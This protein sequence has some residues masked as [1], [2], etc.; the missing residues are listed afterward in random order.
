[1]EEKQLLGSIRIV[2]QNF[3]KSFIRHRGGRTKYFKSYIQQRDHD[4]RNEE[5]DIGYLERPNEKNKE[6]KFRNTD[7]GALRNEWE[8]IKSDFKG[9]HKKS[10]QKQTKEVINAL[11]TFSAGFDLSPENREIQFEAVKKFVEE[12]FDFPIYV[13]QHN[14][15]RTLHYHFSFLN[16]DKK[17]NR[18][19][20]KQINTSKLQDKV[21]DYLKEHNADFGHTRGIPKE[22]TGKENIPILQGKI[23]TLEKENQKLRD[24]IAEMENLQSEI[25]AS[26]VELVGE[27][28]EMGMNYK[29]KSAEELLK[30]FQRH[31]QDEV[32]FNKLFDKV[33]NLANKQ[34][35]F[36]DVKDYERIKASDIKEKIK[37]LGELTQKKK[38]INKDIK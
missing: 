31:F 11:L 35:F 9:K 14:D 23:K 10:M 27:F 7:F 18:P 12:E 29:G 21:F 13:V 3:D 36:S 19:L 6:H 37:A 4:F 22:E 26:M 15:E 16:Y 1:M 5:M 33:V 28:Y 8:G 24:N 34:G 20:A 32:K 2:K 17:T 38:E 25:M 30:L